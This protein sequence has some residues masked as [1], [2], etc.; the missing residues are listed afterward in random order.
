MELLK[1]IV[2]ARKKIRIYPRY[3]RI[4]VNFKKVQKKFQLPVI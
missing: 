4:H 1:V 2:P 3:I